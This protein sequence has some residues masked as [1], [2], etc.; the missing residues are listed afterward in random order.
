MFRVSVDIGGTF[1]DL[2]AMDEEGNLTNIKVPTT[3]RRPE[4]GVLE[5]FRRF[6]E[7]HRPEEVSMVVHA[8]T[9]ATNALFGQLELELPRT[10]LITTRGFRDVI[11]IGRQRRPELYN[12]FFRR[13]RPLVSRRDRYEVDERIDS[14]GRVIK[15][16]S[17]REV[18]S[19]AEKIRMEGIQTVAIGFLNSYANPIHEIE[20]KKIMESE[21]P[22]VFVTASCEVSPE[23]REYERIST[24]VVNAVLMPI[25]HTYI[26]RLLEGLRRIGVRAPLYIMQSSGGLTPAEDVSHRPA[27]IVESG[28]ASGVVASTFYGRLLGLGDILSFDMGGTT[29]KAGAVRG[30]KPEMVTEYE[31]GGRVHKG[32][33]VK[34]SGYPVRFPFI[35]LAECSAGGGTIAWVDEGGSLRVGPLSAGAHPG[36]ACYGL[37]GGKPTITDANLLLGRLPNSLI[38]GRLRLDR[39]LA[40]EAVRREISEPL[41]IDV[42]EASSS[43]IRVANS[44]M[45]KILRIVSVER[46]YDPRD[47]TLIAFGGAGPMH[48][49]A[50]AEELGIS[51][52][53]V[54]VN[55]GL[56][57]A[58]G[59]LVSDVKYTFVRAL[60]AKV[61]EVEAERLETL[62]KELEHEGWRTLKKDGFTDDHIVFIR[63]VDA[64][65]LG[66]SYE[67]TIPAE[68]PFTEA[69]VE[70]LE[71][72]FHERHR[73]IYGYMERSEPVEIVNIRLTAIGLME[74]PKPRRRRLEE[75]EPPRESLKGF[76]MVYFEDPDEY[77]RCPIYQRERLK[78]GN[79]VDG[80]L[81]VE[82]YDSTTVIYPGWSLLVD[83]YGNLKI[84]REGCHEG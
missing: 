34:G 20:V 54:P 70:R 71:A 24:A 69:G 22:G 37:G 45:A 55:P 1:T 61:D 82:Q 73:L 30:G 51:R 13:P 76:R 3:P 59:L 49:C 80:P 62:F 14:K 52:I 64:R 66:Q 39:R 38:G 6:L 17:R 31:V 60:M 23:Y 16:L 4:A 47:F 11:E 46:G 75:A 5:A 21:C 8:T 7:S 56:F 15:P 9:I 81:V 41:G 28:P 35:D 19:I 25:V 72:S 84:E 36:P 58:L 44:L 12:L 26:V 63:E 48:A 43:I 53:I 29:A 18:S 50:L 57:S 74:K 2:V 79:R 65:Y 27:S 83:C 77:V 68:R 32:R 33:I 78:P 42:S 40:E 67:L 10:A